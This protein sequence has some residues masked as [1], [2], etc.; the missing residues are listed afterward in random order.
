M[1]GVEFNEERLS[2][3]VHD[4]RR[5]EPVRAAAEPPARRGDVGEGSAPAQSL[6]RPGGRRQVSHSLPVS[7]SRHCPELE[8]MKGASFAR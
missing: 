2:L 7:P 8:N 1:R 5:T 6:R 3:Q 4:R